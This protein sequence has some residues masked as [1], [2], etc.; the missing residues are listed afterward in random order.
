MK[1]KNIPIDLIDIAD[2]N[3]R[4]DFSFGNDVSDNL[5]K[6][7]MKSVAQTLMYLAGNRVRLTVI[8]DL[9][10]DIHY[11]D[12]ALSI[13]ITLYVLYNVVKRLKETFEIFLQGVPEGLDIEDIKA[14]I[15]GIEK[16][17]VCA[18]FAHLVVRRRA[19]RVY[20][21]CKIAEYQSFQSNTCC[22]KEYQRSVKAISLQ[23]LYHRG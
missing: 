8:K 20:C 6:E 16:N 22:K 9:L 11:L 4:K 3:V 10:K 1:I 17:S 14:R 12:P 19:S 18:S 2:E 21:S 23:P 7:H 15:L 13:A 5:I